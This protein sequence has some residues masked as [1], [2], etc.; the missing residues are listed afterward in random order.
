MIK[1]ILPLFL[2]LI[3]PLLAVYESKLIEKIDIISIGTAPISEGQIKARL[4]SREGDFFSQSAFDADLK[5]LS[6][7]FDRVEPQVILQD[8]SLF[9][10]LKIRP[11]PKIAFITFE[12]NRGITQAALQEEL[13]ISTGASFDRMEFNK[14][15]HK[16]KALYVKNGYFEASLEYRVEELAETQE[17][18][19]TVSINEGRCGKVKEI[20][21]RNFTKAE[22]NDILNFMVTKRYNLILSWFNGQGTYHEEAVQQDR[23]MI[24]NYLQNEGYAD[25]DVQIEVVE[26]AKN[27]I[28]VIITADKGERYYF[29]DVTFSGNTLYSDEVIRSKILAKEGCPYSPDVLNQTVRALMDFYGRCGYIEAYINYIPKLNEGSNAFSIEITIEEGEPFRVGLIRVFGNCSTKTKVILHETLLTPGEVF[30]GERL[31]QTEMRLRNVGYFKNVNVYAVKSEGP[32]VLPENYRDVHI[33]VEETATGHFGA[34]AGGSSNEGF[35]AGANITEKNFNI[36]GIPYIL[37]DGLTALRGGGEYAHLAATFG[38]KSLSYTF[39]WTKPYFMDTPWTIGLDLEKSTNR[40][41]SDDYTLRTTGATLSFSYQYNVFTRAGIHYR[42]RYS[43][44]DVKKHGCKDETDPNNPA[45]RSKEQKKA[46]GIGLTSAV[47]G[48]WAYDSTNHPL[49]PTCGFRSR[50]EEEF[51][52][53]GGDV[54]YVSFAYL[55]TWYYNLWDQAVFKSRLDLK[56]MQPINGQGFNE[57]PLDERF[58]LGGDETIRGYRPYRPGPKLGKCSNDPKG[59]A[60]LQF[61]SVEL[62]RKLFS[63]MDGFI[64]CDAGY[65]SDDS[66]KVGE[67]WAAAGIGARIEIMENGPPVMLGVGFPI[68][69]RGSTD[70][71]RFFFQMGGRF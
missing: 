16:L 22:E 20:C 52:G 68:N 3:T 51:A 23:F 42:I 26:A 8:D 50:F 33:E 43:D 40:Y 9:I 65:L 45:L 49:K 18:G 61:Y 15:F 6:Q 12:G 66:W 64:F 55:N 59:G 58:F 7:D 28:N 35:F 70:V 17:V 11:K 4:T 48:Y 60:S 57:I 67:P 24:L 46:D 36:A 27:R 13:G 62:S 1:K 2:L 10:T 31:K 47:G 19:I 34:S 69:P 30:N 39:S 37:S 25:A 54:F 63:R 53:V 56:F 38:T 32:S 29:G 14:A 5:M 41:I 21:F 71:K 44:D